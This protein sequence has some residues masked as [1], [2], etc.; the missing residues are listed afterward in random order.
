MLKKVSITNESC[1]CIIV[2]PE[3]KQMLSA[4]ADFGLTSYPSSQLSLP[5][6]VG[7]VQEYRIVGLEDEHIPSQASVIINN[8]ST[9]EP[10]KAS[11]LQIEGLENPNKRLKLDDGQ[12]GAEQVPSFPL[13]AEIKKQE[14]GKVDTPPSTEGSKT[15]AIQSA[16]AVK[17]VS[18]KKKKTRKPSGKKYSFKVK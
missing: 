17:S 4:I 2:Y 18:S 1:Y 10:E 5:G 8:P 14:I 6:L 16:P 3:Q 7:V 15:A 13:D 11:K 9:S 12:Q